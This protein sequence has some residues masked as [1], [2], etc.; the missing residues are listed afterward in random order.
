MYQSCWLSPTY[1]GEGVTLLTA[2]T[3]EGGNADF[4]CLLL[5]LLLASTSY[6]YSAMNVRNFLS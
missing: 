2:V 5:S 3:R 4:Y 1:Q 6:R